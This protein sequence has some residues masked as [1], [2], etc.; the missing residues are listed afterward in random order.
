M[1]SFRSWLTGR[2][3]RAFLQQTKKHLGGQSSWAGML[4]NDY[5][6]DTTSNAAAGGGKLKVKTKELSEADFLAGVTHKQNEAIKVTQVGALCNVMLAA[7]KGSVGFMV[8]STGLIADGANS[9]GDLLCDLVVWYT[10]VESR[11]ASTAERPWGTGKLEPI[12]ALTVGALLLTTGLGIG[13]TAFGVS[14]ETA[15]DLFPVIKTLPFL[16]NGSTLESLDAALDS[17]TA[18]VLESELELMYA[19]IGV[20]M[21]SVAVKEALF[22]YTIRAGERATSSAVIANA[23]QHRSD[24]IVSSAVCVG[25]I[26]KMY[27]YPILDPLAGLLV[28]GVIVKQAFRTSLDSLKDLSDI[29]AEPAETAALVKECMRVPGIRQVVNLHARQSG[30]YLYVEATLGVD[31][32]ISASAAHRLAEL[33]RKQMLKTFRGRVSNAVI[34]VDPLGST[35]LGENSP[36]WAQ[37][38]DIVEREVNKALEPI[39]HHGGITG[40][41][42]VQVYYRD[43]GSVNVKVDVRMSPELTIKEAH[44]LANKARLQIEKALPGVGEVDVDLELDE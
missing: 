43:D 39:Y 8:G 26:G 40:I 17:A 7:S 44:N 41:S 3:A 10:V 25:L 5:H 28:A 18:S 23:Y 20:S 21:V 13:Y 29:P 27:G 35:G 16:G 6:A 22:H 24:A 34:H 33:A 4:V 31:G 12:G 2:N 38:H 42:E 9:L 15:A 30:P 19:A 11:K 14:L 37:N 1:L 32:S 36:E